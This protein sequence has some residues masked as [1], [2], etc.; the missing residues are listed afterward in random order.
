M[1]TAISDGGISASAAAGTAEPITYAVTGTVSSPTS[2]AVGGLSVQLVDQ[3]VGGDAVLK[4]GE[5]NGQGQFTLEAPISSATLAARHKTSPD[6]QVQ[7]LLKGEVAASS[8]V[9][10][11]APTAVVLDVVLPSSF[12][13]PSEYEALTGMLAPLYP[14]P[15]AGLQE[16]AA[17]QDI[18]YLS[19]K[20]AC[21]PRMVA[22]VSL[23]AQF[24]QAAD[25][26]L[27]THAATTATEPAAAGAPA[28]APPLATGN[29]SAPTI[30][31]GYY[32]AL[33]RAGLPTTPNAL[34]R[35]DPDLVETIWQQAA[36][37]GVIPSSL[38]QQSSASRQAFLQ[39]A[40]AGALDAAPL[41]GPST[42][43]QLLQVVL[44]N[45]TTRQQEFANLLVNNP[46]DTTAL[47]VQVEQS[48]GTA[49][50]AQLQLLGQLAF[51]TANNAPLLAALYQAQHNS[52]AAP[53]DLVTS[54]YYQASA[55][56]TLLAN[57]NPPAEIAGATTAEQ[58][59]NYA[60]FLAAQ[61]RISF[62]TA[63]VAQLAN[64][65]SLGTAALGA[66]VGSF[67]MT[68]QADFDIGDEPIAQF[69]ARTGTSA[70]AELVQ[71]ITGI[72]RIYQ[73]TPDATTMGTLLGAG[74]TSAYAITKLGQASFVDTYAHNLGGTDIAESI[75]T[76]AQSI[77]NATVHVALSYL[78][79]KQ[80]PALGTGALSSIVNSFPSTPAASQP[81]AA[82]QATLEDLFG[83]LDY[84]QGCDCQSITSPAAYLVDLL[85][86]I[87]NTAP[88]AGYQNPLRALLDRRP[89]IAT[90][91]LTCDNTN[92]A[93]PYIDLVNETLE[94]F[95]GNAAPNSE[96]NAAPN[97]ESL[98]HFEGY[99]DDGT[100]SSAELI[101]SP[102]NDD[103][104]VAQNAYSVLKS[105]WSPPPLP[106]YRDLELLRQYVG[107]FQISLYQLMESLRTTENLEPPDASNPNAYG[108]RDILSE[109]L[110]LSRLEYRLLTDSTL[111]LAQIYGFPSTTSTATIISTISS[112]QEFSRR[113]SVSY[114]DIV[115]ILQT[116]FIN[117][118][119]ALIE[120]MAALA[121]PFATLQALNGG[122]LKGAQFEARLPTGLDMTGYGP[123]G[124][125][126]WVTAN[127]ST[128]ADLIV[129]DVAGAPCDTS[130]MRLQYLNGSA[131]TQAD[132]VRLLRFIRLWQK[133]GLSVQQT[134]ALISALNGNSSSGSA[135][136]QLDSNFLVLL[137]RTG[138][139][140]RA[141]DLLGLDPQSDL[142]SLLTCWAPI[143]SSGTGSL[144]A[145]MFLNPT[146]LAI[147]PVFAPDI[148]GELFTGTPAPLLFAH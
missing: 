48:L 64:S 91:P 77:T 46:H 107:Y 54:G 5:T 13:L 70:S 95:V 125:A 26:V 85:D 15:L 75:F 1:T 23:A 115:S 60:D 68:H 93:L 24:S 146:V 109:R 105:Q 94:Y 51:L 19:G 122:T 121:V 80:S 55:W 28:P 67:L 97:S 29:G 101:A 21:D 66:G 119:S 118:A 90:L 62:P 87:D 72:Q 57:V 78:S 136:Q 18:T 50:S 14:G 126:A 138:L 134:D 96:S 135:L 133:L 4:S 52:L 71:Q 83:D 27:S 129:I 56:G 140:Y 108:W 147:D 32:S 86:Y 16:S 145:Q 30:D 116:K 74:L 127:F 103:N 49:V 17:S 114:A 124:P 43:R 39:V 59:A 42:L 143:G 2:V 102:Q 3:N 41:V 73:I 25:A 12:P 53:V 142:S 111:S 144:Y 6:L 141:M 22:M 45:D 69:L 82:A 106:F 61:V 65:G 40:A 92:T 128:L 38:G 100:V 7:V 132:C 47:W 76:R 63:T 35:V 8:V 81:G 58:K 117:P 98:V 33:F 9:Q 99:N 36:D 20:S 34:Y 11:N 113:T 148:H 37:Q 112:L 130:Q 137:P 131:L 110:G 84:C 79:A 88:T 120:L 44:G 104:T 10:Y 89:D 123:E 31:P 139:A